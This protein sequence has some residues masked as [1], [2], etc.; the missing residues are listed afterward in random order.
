MIGG[1][2][3]VNACRVKLATRRFSCPGAL[4]ELPQPY[5]TNVALLPELRRSLNGA[6]ES[7]TWCSAT[8]RMLPVLDL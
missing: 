2:A 7:S 1:R 4:P 8:E 3:R 6:P 5:R